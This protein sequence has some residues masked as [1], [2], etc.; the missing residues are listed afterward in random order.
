MLRAGD[1]FDRYQVED[2]LGE[3]GMGL[4]YRA[5]DTRLRRRIALKIV[6]PEVAHTADGRTLSEAALRLIRE[7]KAASA[8]NHPNAVAVYEVGE[9]D[10]VPFIAMELVEGHALNEYLGDPRVPM[11]RR[12]AW[13]AGVARGL[14]AAHA[15]GLVHRDVKPENVMVCA[16]DLV[17]VLDFGVAKEIKKSLARSQGAPKRTEHSVV[18][19]AGVVVGTP[20]Y[21]APEQVLDEPL[22]GRSDQ[23]AWASMA[24]ELLSG[25]VHPVST[26]NP[27]NLPLQFAVLRETPLRLDQIAPEVPRPVAD[28]VMRA[29]SK[30]PHERF[31][32]MEEIADAL[33]T[34]LGRR[35]GPLAAPPRVDPSSASTLSVT[36]ALPSVRPPPPSR[37]EPPPESQDPLAPADPQATSGPYVAPPRSQ[38]PI[39]SRGTASRRGGDIHP[40]LGWALVALAALVAGFVAYFIFGHVPRR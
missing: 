21:M 17:K 34:Q 32:T 29:L 40:A 11:E 30:R 26:N 38:L 7:G 6:R 33:E 3:G 23:F 15:S 36:V 25:G 16:G 12:V 5:L 31:A 37:P 28:I 19:M 27:K 18:T 24:Y 13:L 4:V 35:S 1:Q 2:V 14:G 39:L 22:D 9:V 10:G 8:F 20:L